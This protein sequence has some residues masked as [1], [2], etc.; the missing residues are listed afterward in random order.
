MSKK[1]TKGVSIRRETSFSGKRCVG[2]D[3]GPIISLINNEKAFQEYADIL[4]ESLFNYTH[5]ECIGGK[6][7]KIENSEVFKTLTI[8]YNFNLDEAKTKISNFLVSIK[9]K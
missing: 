5:E 3:S 7:I 8:K 4:N 1:E 6:E 2:L 9:L